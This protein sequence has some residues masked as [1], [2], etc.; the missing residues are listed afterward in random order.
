MGRGRT[1]LGW[2]IAGAVAL[3]SLLGLA[4]FILVE[5]ATVASLLRAS[6]A[7]LPDA[8]PTLPDQLPVM[9]AGIRG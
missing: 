9:Y 5:P 4:G 3:G 8:G 6:L 7:M 2:Q 1:E